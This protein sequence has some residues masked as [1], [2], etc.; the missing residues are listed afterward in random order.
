MT[1]SSPQT[2]IDQPVNF[3]FLS[4]QIGQAHECFLGRRQPL[5]LA[6]LKF[7]PLFPEVS[8]SIVREQLLRHV[9]ATPDF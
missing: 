1:A 6:S 7:V 2:F 9:L 3:K 8:A 4:I 5:I